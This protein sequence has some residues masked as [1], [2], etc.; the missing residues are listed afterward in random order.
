MMNK[1]QIATMATCIAMVGVVAVGGTLAL[2]TS[3]QKTLTNTFTVGS[4]FVDPEDPKEYVFKLDEAMAKQNAGGDY[5]AV[6]AIQGGAYQFVENLEEAT[7]VEGTQSYSN[8]QTNTTIDKDPTFY[9]NA[10]YAPKCWVVAY[11]EN[12]TDLE[13]GAVGANWIPVEKSGSNWVK[14]ENRTA[15]GGYYIYNTLMGDNAPKTNPLFTEVT[16]DDTLVSGDISNIV[17]KGIAVQTPSEDVTSDIVNNA[18][19]LKAVMEEASKAVK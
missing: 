14:D 7:R 4:G 3:E 6:K 16:A 13:I 10:E 18:E 2:L 17:I 19:A 8:V 9:V 11:V 1:K 5:Q 15:V 12:E